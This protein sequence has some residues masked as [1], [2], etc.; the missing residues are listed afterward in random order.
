M[1]TGMVGV[2]APVILQNLGQQ[3]VA[4][5]LLQNLGGIWGTGAGS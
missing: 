2:F 4:G 3:G 1:D 5:S